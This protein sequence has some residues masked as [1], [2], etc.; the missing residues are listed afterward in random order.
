MS[1]RAK[2]NLILGLTGLLGLAISALVV[3]SFLEQGARTEVLGS[4]RMILQSARAV[5]HY[6]TTQ[7]QPILQ[8]QLEQKFHPQSVPAFSANQFVAKLRESYP[9]YNYKEAVL[10]PTNP[11]NRTSDW[12]ADMVNSYKSDP[13][14]KEL[15]VERETPTGRFLYLSQPIVVNDVSCLVC[16]DTPERAPASMVALYGA[17]NGFGWK[18]KDTIGAQIV[19]IPMEVPLARARHAFYLL[20]GSLAAVLVVVGILLNVLLHYV[21]IRPVRRM[22]ENA[23]RVSLGEMGTGELVIPGNDEIAS[24]SHSFNR[25][26]RSLLNAMKILDDSDMDGK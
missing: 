3:R 4:A 20:V 10:N 15:V 1:L 21:V 9:Q 12:E 2:F 16:H 17:S 8:P 23:N 6:T 25:M 24:L 5:R 19:S 22:A 18:L 7:I 26:H 11:A 13:E 14:Q